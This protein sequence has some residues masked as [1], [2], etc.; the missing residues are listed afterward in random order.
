MCVDCRELAV[1]NDLLKIGTASLTWADQLNLAG[2]DIVDLAAISQDL[3][4]LAKLTRMDLC[5]RSVGN[6][7]EPLP[8][9][10]GCQM[11]RQP[12]WQA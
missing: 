12:A 3:Q 11:N 5:S 10:S 8:S 7:K 9:F 1:L 2:T 4:C 6:V